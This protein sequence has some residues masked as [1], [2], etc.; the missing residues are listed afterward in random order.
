MSIRP[1]LEYIWHRPFR[2]F[3]PYIG[4]VLIPLSAPIAS[5]V[6]GGVATSIAF[7]PNA[8]R[9]VRIDGRQCRQCAHLGDPALTMT[10]H[11]CALCRP[12]G[13]HV[14]Q[15]GAL[16]ADLR[17]DAHWLAASSTH[18]SRGPG[19]RLANRRHTWAWWPI[20]SASSP[21]REWARV[22]LADRNPDVL[23]LGSLSE[24]LLPLT[25]AWIEPIADMERL[26]PGALH[27]T[28]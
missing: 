4:S 19:W 20:N 2:I 24:K 16:H 6:A 22:S 23:D 26:S 11:R 21:Q 5:S 14:P 8:N 17:S 18:G 28:G 10:R 27:V 13:A 7:L 9:G 3:A 1:M 12:V 15:R 25:L